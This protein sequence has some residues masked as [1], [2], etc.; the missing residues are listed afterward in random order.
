M[1]DLNFISKILGLENTKRHF[2][3][4]SNI[5][6]VSAIKTAF[7]KIWKNLN[8]LLI[9]NHQVL[10]LSH[11]MVHKLNLIHIIIYDVVRL[12]YSL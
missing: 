4:L 5:E 12:N 3:R 6:I 1:L 9:Q 10:L 8:R 2:L 7:N 11:H